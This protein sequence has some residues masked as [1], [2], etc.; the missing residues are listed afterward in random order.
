[1]WKIYIYVHYLDVFFM[2]TVEN[3]LSFPFLITWFYSGFSKTDYF[4]IE[5]FLYLI[6]MFSTKT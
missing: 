6:Y 3:I 4:G 5:I 1:M 2:E